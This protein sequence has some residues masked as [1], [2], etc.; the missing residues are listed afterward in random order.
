MLRPALSLRR[1]RT[2]LR[3]SRALFARAQAQ[4]Q[5]AL[6]VPARGALR[7][8]ERGACKA[9]ANPTPEMCVLRGPPRSAA[10]PLGLSTHCALLPCLSDLPGSALEGCVQSGSVHLFLS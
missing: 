8:N 9:S 3:A 6:A 2:V 10:V 1:L 7:E 5:A 4:A